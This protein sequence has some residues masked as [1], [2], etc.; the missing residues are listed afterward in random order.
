MKTALITGSTKGI[1]LEIARQLAGHGFHVW[2]SGRSENAGKKALRALVKTG[3]QAGFVLMNVADHDSIRRAYEIVSQECK[4]LDVLVNNAAVQPDSTMNILKVPPDVVYETVHINVLGAIFVTQAFAPLLKKG[5]RVINVSSTGGQLTTGLGDWAPIYCI[6][7]TALNAVTVQFAKAFKS[8]GIAVN[9]VS[10]GWV[11]TDMG[12]PA[13]P[14]SVAQGAETPV[15]LATEAPIEH[16]GLHWQD[17]KV[18]AW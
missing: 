17:K 12:G 1:G 13:A 8:K 16:T 3:A 18:I 14:R 7:K 15:W 2:L 6:S 9:S 5:S 11:R 4:R 10:P